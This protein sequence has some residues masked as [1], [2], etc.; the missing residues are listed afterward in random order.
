MQTVAGVFDSVDD[1][2]R[3]RESILRAGFD[4]NLVRVQTQPIRQSSDS[5]A[6]ADDG[7]MASIGRFFIDLFGTDNAHASHYSEAV[8]RGGSVVVVTVHDESRVESARA[9]LAAAGAVDIDK[10]VED[11]R[12]QGYTRFDPAARPLQASEARAM[13]GSSRPSGTAGSR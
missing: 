2:E 10:R 3:A 12:Q 11:W 5:V 7:V 6:V 9:A 13:D 8:R 4:K 1:A